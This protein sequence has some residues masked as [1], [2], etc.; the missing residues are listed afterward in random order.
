MSL[1]LPPHDAAHPMIRQSFHD[2]ALG[3]C[4]VLLAFWQVSGFFD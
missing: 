4:L 2:L 1:I 3:L